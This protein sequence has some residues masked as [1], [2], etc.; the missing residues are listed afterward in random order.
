MKKFG[1]LISFVF[2]ITA[3]S[4]GASRYRGDLNGDGRVDLTDLCVLAKAINDGSAGESCDINTSGRVDDND[5]H[6]L[7]SIILSETLTTDG[8]NAGIGG[9]DEDDTDY[10]GTVG[11]RAMMKS[12]GDNTDF[13]LRDSRPEKT[14]GYSVEFGIDN[15]SEALCAVL[16]NISLPR[17]VELDVTRLAELSGNLIGGHALYGKPVVKNEGDDRRRLRFI[18][19]SP[20]LEPFRNK[21]G[22][23]GRIM[24]EIETDSDRDSY[25]D[26]CQVLTSGGSVAESVH[27]HNTGNIEWRPKVPEYTLGEVNGDDK[28]N[29]SDVVTLV[30]YLSEMNPANFI[31]EAADVNQD[32]KI[33]IADVVTLINLISNQ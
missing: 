7:A 15:S 10:G 8:V 24:Y 6:A 25:F 4:S 13:Y 21:T 12:V 9:W 18:V 27:G 14:G 23:L 31:V 3:V 29:I 16:F 28:I 33:N 26:G 2:L 32:G 5:L 1:I 30:N 22:A 11:Y 17:E 20:T 19:F